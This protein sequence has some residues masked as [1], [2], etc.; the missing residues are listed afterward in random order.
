MLVF[1]LTLLFM[2]ALLDKTL[3]IDRQRMRSLEAEFELFAIRDS[4]L[5]RIA[6]GEQSD[7]PA[8]KFFEDLIGNT[9]TNLD[10]PL[11]WEFAVVFSLAESKAKQDNET[12]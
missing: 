4:L 3:R 1:I 9:K 7:N 12:A 10:A 8:V 2:L 6:S 11:L 5:L